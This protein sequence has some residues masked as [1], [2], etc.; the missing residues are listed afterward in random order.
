MNGIA[1]MKQQASMLRKQGKYQEAI[2]LYRELWDGNR[3]QCDEW[4]GWGYAHSL[5]KEGRSQDALDICR[6][7]YQMKPD[8]DYN[9]SLYG[10][11]I[12]DLE[13]KR[14]DAQIE[15]NEGR[16]LKAANAILGE[17]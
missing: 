5:R 6:Q 2:P 3:D 13:I 10:W 17:C 16:F 9:K 11:C 14:D 8:F 7:V 15:Q 4:D 1:E 12:Y